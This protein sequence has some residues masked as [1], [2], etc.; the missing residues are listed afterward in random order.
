MTLRILN[1]PIVQITAFAVV[2][3]SVLAVVFPHYFPYPLSSFSNYANQL[4]LLMLMGG[5][6]FLLLRQPRLTFLSFAG[7]AALC[8]F[9]KYSN[10][11]DGIN[12]WRSRLTPEQVVLKSKPEHTNQLRVAHVNLS[13]ATDIDS[14][15]QALRNCKAGLISLHELDP[16]W[17]MILREELS[18]AYP[19]QEFYVDIGLYGMGIISKYRLAGID[20]LY[21]D[22]VPSLRTAISVDG[23]DLRLFSL[24]SE[25]LIHESARKK[26]LFQLDTVGTLISHDSL[27]SLVFGEFNLMTWS[28]ELQEFCKTAGLHESRNGFMHYVSKGLGSLWE[29]PFDHIFFTSP[30][31][32][33][34][35]SNFLEP[36]TGKRLGIIGAY[37]VQNGI[38]YVE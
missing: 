21:F 28:N 13:N 37:Q 24:H 8:L 31:Q 9:L 29:T 23:Q 5:L 12:R 38:T 6:F 4:M 7:S 32:V 11:S 15:V 14:T 27:P 1:H 30:L 16:M 34:E 26:L 19:F 25:P 18:S 2:G 35:F 10:N 3:V 22:G 33:V 20:T 17:E 36:G